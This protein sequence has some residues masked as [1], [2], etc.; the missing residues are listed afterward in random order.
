VSYSITYFSHRATGGRNK[1][2]CFA[3]VFFYA[4]NDH[5]QPLELARDARSARHDPACGASARGVA[6][7]HHACC[8]LGVCGESIGAKDVNEKRDEISALLA[9]GTYFAAPILSPEQAAAYHAARDATPSY[10]EEVADRIIADWQ[11]GGEV[12]IETLRGLIIKVLEDYD[13]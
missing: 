11:A 13:E 5:N 6:F 2:Q 3:P 8:C 9:S 7:G 4:R 10:A 1:Q 12:K